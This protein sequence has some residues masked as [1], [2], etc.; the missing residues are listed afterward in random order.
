MD[1]VGGSVLI[2]AAGTLLP[3]ELFE[4]IDGNRTEHGEVVVGGA[5]GGDLATTAGVGAEAGLDSIE[6]VLQRPLVPW[7]SAR[8]LPAAASR[9]DGA[10]PGHCWASSSDRRRS[11][12]S[13]SRRS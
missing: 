13:M 9:R 6:L 12:R 7:V 5:E 11:S 10:P 3:V 2:D 4:G 1:L 8:W